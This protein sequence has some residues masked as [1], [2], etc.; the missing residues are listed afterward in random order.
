[1]AFEAVSYLVSAKPQK[2]YPGL[3]LLQMPKQQHWCEV[4][5]RRGQPRDLNKQTT[6]AHNL[7]LVKK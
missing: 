5:N 3:V 2:P 7:W 1:M 6:P 4:M